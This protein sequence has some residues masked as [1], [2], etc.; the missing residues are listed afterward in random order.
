MKANYNNWIPN[1]LLNVIK[2]SAIAL[3]IIA[4]ILTYWANKN[5]ELHMILISVSLVL[6]LVALVLTYFQFK[7]TYMRNQFSYDDP[8]SLAWKIINFTAS[9]LASETTNGKV[10]DVGCGSGAL[11]IA[12]AKHN[13]NVQ[14]TGL[15]RWG[16]DYQSEFSKELC[17]NNAIAEGVSNVE[18]VAG[19]A[20]RLPF[21]D[22]SFDA[23]CSNYVYHNIPGDRN[24]I[25]QESFRVLKKGGVFAIHDL[26]TKSKYPKIDQLIDQ[27]KADGFESI[28]LIDTTDGTVMSAQQAKKTMLTGSKLLCGKK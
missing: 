5:T 11:S 20:K 17:Q 4:I 26:F 22:D 1:R 28:T 2:G 19:D 21:A 9:K 10:L 13:P 3:S 7:F 14:I 16:V 24:K 8:N 23:I 12:V 25:L 18:F 6:V 27:L 15:D